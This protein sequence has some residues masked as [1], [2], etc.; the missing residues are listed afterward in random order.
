VEARP[1]SQNTDSC[2]PIALDAPM[3]C[4]DSRSGLVRVCCAVTRLVQGLNAGIPLAGQDL[5]APLDSCHCG[6]SRSK[7]SSW[8]SGCGA[9]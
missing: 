1:I 7:E 5:W 2:S 6:A 4:R 8:G 3:L 9:L